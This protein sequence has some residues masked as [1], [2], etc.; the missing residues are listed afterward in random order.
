MYTTRSLHNCKSMW[1]EIFFEFRF[2][3]VRVRV[4]SKRTRVLTKDTTYLI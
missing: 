1:I 2:V 4:K 3:R